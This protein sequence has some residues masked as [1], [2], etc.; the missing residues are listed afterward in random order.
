MFSIIVCS[1]DPQKRKQLK[2]NI[3]NTIGND[4]L[5]EFIAI[6]NN[7]NPQSIAKVYNEGAELAKYPYLLFIHEDAGFISHNW[8]NIII[9]KL[10]EQDCGAVGFAGSKIMFNIPGGWGLDTRYMVMNTKEINQIIRVNSDPNTSF[11]EVISLDGF[12]F[13]VRREVW[14][15]HRFD[16]QA[17][18]GFHCYDIDFSLDIAK[19][20][21]NYVCNCI[22]TFHNS[23][24]S[25]DSNWFEQTLLIFNNKWSHFLPLYTSEIKLTNEEYIKLEE[26]AYF[27]LIRKF[28]SL[29]LPTKQLYRRF[30][31]YRLNFRHFE[32]LFRVI[33]SLP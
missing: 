11:T 21:K 14:S 13:F 30:I 5:F 33:F 29:K 12:A 16:E 3:N 31:K 6:D 25:Y 2:E 8:G 4:V 27:H 23:C 28:K 26:R 18:T 1:I 10:K 19:T 32:H 24:G 9:S 15:K 20:H 7:E 17:L 22:E